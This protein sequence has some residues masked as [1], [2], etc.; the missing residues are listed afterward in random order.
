MIDTKEGTIIMHQ[1]YNPNGGLELTRY[2]WEGGPI[3]RIS[4]DYLDDGIAIHSTKP[5]GVIKFGPYRLKNLGMEPKWGYD[6]FIFIRLDY[7][8]WWVVCLFN[9][10]NKLI[11]LFY[12]RSITTMSIW[13]LARYDPATIPTWRDIYAVQWLQ[14]KFNKKA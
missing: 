11:D 14:R 5:G 3:T 13:R 1:T 7:P 8:F 9:R 6:E 12:R 2:E 10:W 4:R